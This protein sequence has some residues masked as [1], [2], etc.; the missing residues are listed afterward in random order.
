MYGASTGYVSDG[1][2]EQRGSSAL[3]CGQPDE[4]VL[5][6]FLT[7]GRNRIVPISVSNETMPK[8]PSIPLWWK[9][10]AFPPFRWTLRIYLGN[11]AYWPFRR[12]ETFGRFYY[13]IIFL[14]FISCSLGLKTGMFF[15]SCELTDLYVVGPLYQAL[16]LLL[17]KLPR[18]SPHVP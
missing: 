4:P 2:T 16:F 15:P 12:F 1:P 13:P 14:I 5:A 3:K 11:M 10:E 18:F 8:S 17:T 9:G 7:E 6:R